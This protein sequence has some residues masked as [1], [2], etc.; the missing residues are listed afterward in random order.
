MTSQ[1]NLVRDR[2]AS[3]EEALRLIAS[4]LLYPSGGVSLRRSCSSWSLHQ[5]DHSEQ[6]FELAFDDR[7]PSAITSTVGKRNVRYARLKAATLHAA[8]KNANNRLVRLVL[9]FRK[10]PPLINAEVIYP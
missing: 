3:S 7:I 6:L 8:L 5:L 1:T 4:N 2:Y 9:N 10:L